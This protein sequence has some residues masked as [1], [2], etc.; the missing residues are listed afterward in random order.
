MRSPY[1]YI[2]LIFT[3]LLFAA[4]ANHQ[5]KEQ[6]SF[7]PEIL[8]ESLSMELIATSPSI[9]TPIGLAIDSQDNI[10]A[11]ESHTHQPPSDYAGPQFDR[12]KKGV[13]E[14]GDGKPESWIIFAD[15][16]TDGMNLAVGPDDVI[17]LTEKDRVL[18]FQDTDKDGK[19]DKKRVLLQMHTPR[20]VYDHAGILGITYGPDGWLYVSRGNS[21]SLAYKIAG[22]DGT[23]IDG[24]GDGGNVFRCR[25]DGSAVEEVATG[26][27]NPFDLTFTQQGH[28]ML[29]DND[30]DSR[31][32]NRLLDI[33]PG[34]DYG[35]QSLYGGSGIHPFLAWNG[36]LPGTLPYAAALGEAPSGVIDAS[37][38]NSQTGCE[39]NILAT[40]W[41]ENSIVRVPLKTHQSN[42]QGQAEV[43]VQGDSTFHPVALATNSKGELYITDWVVR[44]YPNHGQGRIWR[45]TSKGQ[46]AASA[47][48]T[49]A[50]AYEEETN[51]FSLYENLQGFDQHREALQS[52]DPFLQAVA[53]KSLGKDTSFH[54]YLLALSEDR[55]EAM[56][57]QALLALSGS[58]AALN[59]A[60][61]KSFLQ[62]ENENVRR[63]TLIYIVTHARTDLLP[64]VKSA[65]YSGDIT[66]SLF[67][68]YLATIRHLQPEYISGYLAKSE[69]N[70]KDIKRELPPNYLMTIIS[71][72]S[73]S[74][75]IRAMA[76]PYLEKSDDNTTALIGMLNNAAP[77]V[78]MALLH[79][80]RQANQK[81]VANAMLKIA[82]NTNADYDL[83]RQ[84]LVAL[85]YQ[86]TVYCEEA[87]GLLQ[88]NDELLLETTVRYLCRCGGNQASHKEIS[89]LITESAH[90][91]TDQLNRI[92][93]LCRGTLT[94]ADKPSSDEAWAQAV[95]GS[96][97]PEKGALIFQLPATQCQTCHKVAGWGG[98][99]GPELTNVGSSKN[100]EQLITAILEPS[101]DISPE[102]QGWFVTDSSGQTHYGRQIDVGN[103]SAELLM[104]GGDF[105]N[106]KKPKSYGLAPTSLMPEGLE[107]TLTQ[108]EFNHLITYLMSLK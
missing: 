20:D 88:E 46:E 105:I 7:M 73:L 72:N 50:V 24:Y 18:S 55:N 64:E 75:E 108:D 19:S 106:F 62:D 47:S 14:N 90:A 76:I 45:M 82:L 92:W 21:G 89:Q 104:P 1:P 3:I 87:K 86:S 68:T 69:D 17:Y 33:V 54:K 85:S 23:S 16:I 2:L 81:E 66:S 65:L 6:P 95:D 60:R 59:K 70:A 77:P 102:W 53:R 79:S 5:E 84:A 15:S 99:F 98:A 49:R 27:W 12:I 32:P 44:Q 38:T 107:N 11:L 43:I 39:N 63:M 97:D 4:C 83:R 41:E 74:T 103:N 25:P 42:V 101:A 13:D 36:E 71:D 9:M 96:G 28:L 93:Q 56:R 94:A 35:Y 100:K 22:T 51:F 48:T 8:D 58:S 57:L 29:V 31:G 40:I 26:F 61:L 91:D 10:Y 80:L 30:P 52:G 78:Q 34:G 67:E 37:F